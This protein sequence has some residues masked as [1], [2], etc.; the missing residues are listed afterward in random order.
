MG[1]RTI[2]MQF[3]NLILYEDCTEEE[4]ITFS[5]GTLEIMAAG[6]EQYKDDPVLGPAA[7]DIYNQFNEIFR[8]FHQ[9]TT[10]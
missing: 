8:G 5:E 9:A 10:H 7:I 4:F 2:A 3:E 6:I 1:E